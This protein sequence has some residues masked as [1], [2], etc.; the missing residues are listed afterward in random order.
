M[1]TTFLYLYLKRP[2]HVIGVRILMLQYY[3]STMYYRQH[4]ALAPGLY[5]S[6][7]GAERRRAVPPPATTRR[8]AG[9]VFENLLSLSAGVGCRAGEVGV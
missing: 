5:E 2:H 7:K 9:E 6:V 8:R 4:R 3:V 1:G